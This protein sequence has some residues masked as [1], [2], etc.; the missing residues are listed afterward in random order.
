[1]ALIEE[2]AEARFMQAASELACSI[3]AVPMPPL[4]VATLSGFVSL[5]PTGPETTL[6]AIAAR[7]VSAMDP[8]RR[9]STTEDTARRQSHPLNAREKELLERWGYPYVFDAY[10]FH[11]TLSERVEG[12]ERD[13]LVDAARR[14][15]ADALDRP[16]AFASLAVFVEPTRGAPFRLM[17]RLPLG[18]ADPPAV[19]LRP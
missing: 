3:G 1:M 19:P 17:R 8:W 10:R 15:F 13:A 18:G 9:A 7:A 12:G 4:A 14:H 16:R 11:L 2:A 5:R 6:A